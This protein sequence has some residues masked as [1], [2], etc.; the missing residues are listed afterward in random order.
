MRPTPPRR[1]LSP[2]AAPAAPAACAS[3]LPQATL[4]RV[5]RGP[6]LSF[7]SLSAFMFCRRVNRNSTLH[8]YTDA[9]EPLHATRNVGITHISS[10]EVIWSIIRAMQVR[11]YDKCT[12]RPEA[13]FG[14]GHANINK[15]GTFHY[16]ALQ[17]PRV[18]SSTLRHN[19]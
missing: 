2:R 16:F 17:P 5:A 13:L 15:C 7:I 8:Y 14:A 6:P 1:L 10:S 9:A 4:I 18:K 11:I 3:R 12:P 19:I